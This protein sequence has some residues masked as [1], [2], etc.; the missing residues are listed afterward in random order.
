M[1]SFVSPIT[2]RFDCEEDYVSPAPDL[3]EDADV[4]GSGS[5]TGDGDEIT[6]TCLEETV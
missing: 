5:G 2:H 3:L 1:N 6:G 4:S